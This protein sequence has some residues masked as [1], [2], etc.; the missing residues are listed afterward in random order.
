EDA[1]RYLDKGRAI[2]PYLGRPD[3]Y[4]M[5][6]AR[7]RGL[8]GDSVYT[9]LKSSYSYIPYAADRYRDVIAMV[10]ARKDTSEIF[11][12]YSLYT[13]SYRFP[14]TSALTATVN[15]LKTAGYP[16]ER[17]VA[18]AQQE[19]VNFPADS[20]FDATVNS[21]QISQYLVE[22]QAYFSKKDYEASLASYYKA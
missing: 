20:A 10:G 6:M 18:F 2:N 3:F 1:I 14:V 5:I 13:N 21:M 19:K 9:Y 15:A 17:L 12:L 11:E 8:G 7:E 4:K 22:G 16:H